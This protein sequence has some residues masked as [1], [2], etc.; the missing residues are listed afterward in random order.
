MTMARQGAEVRLVGLALLAAGCGG[1][2]EKA[3]MMDAAEVRP[4]LM[5]T[6]VFPS[7]ART[8]ATLASWPEN[9]EKEAVA[10]VAALWPYGISSTS[11]EHVALDRQIAIAIV[12]MTIATPRGPLSVRL[13][14]VAFHAKSRGEVD[15]L[16]GRMGIVHETNGDFIL[17]QRR[18]GLRT[19]VIGSTPMMV[20]D[21]LDIFIQARGTDVVMATSL[22]GL[23]AAGSSARAARDRSV[24]GDVAISLYPPAWSAEDRK[25]LASSYLALA[26]YLRHGRDTR[27]Q[28]GRTAGDMLDE[29]DAVFSVKPFFAGEESTFVLTVEAAGARLHA[30]TRPTAPA[31]RRVAPAVAFDRTLARDGRVAALGAVD[32]SPRLIE[33]QRAMVRVWKG[34]GGPGADELARLAAAQTDVL[35]GSCSFAVRTDGEIWSVESSY[36]VRVGAD[37]AP[38]EQAYVAAIRSGGLP[39]LQSAS[40]D[41]K[42]AKFLL[43]HTDGV[44][45]LDRVL[46]ND[47]SVEARHTAAL[48]GGQVLQDRIAVKGDRLLVVSGARADQQIADLSRPHAGKLPVEV[49]RELATGRGKGGFI[50]V[51]VMGVW[52]PYLKA[53]QVVQSPLSGLVARVPDLAKRRLPLVVTLEPTA[54]IDAT[55]AMPTPTFSFLWGVAAVLGSVDRR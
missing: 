46:A 11:A 42:T 22:E 32:C 26:K 12:G 52:A 13:D 53:A 23:Q 6:I 24:K 14:A 1:V 4:S 40:D 51:D 36:P 37:P 33:R 38:L 20:R 48:Y 28:Q 35:D 47:G 50:F 55:V 44:I 30:V 3:R 49:E 27:A 2:F 41:L 31:A 10:R 19:A 21:N 29:V 18:K 25:D 45:G 39:N 34:T 17:V 54:G 16:A 43:S 15:D 8:D 7:L 9:P 5:A